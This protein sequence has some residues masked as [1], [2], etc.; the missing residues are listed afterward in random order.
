MAEVRGVG[1]HDGLVIG[2]GKGKVFVGGI[3]DDELLH[4]H[5]Y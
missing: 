4:H 2:S 1:T 3:K 5:F